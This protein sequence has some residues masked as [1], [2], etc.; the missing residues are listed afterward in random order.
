MRIA[1]RTNAAESDLEEIA[2]YIGVAEH[3]PATADRIIDEL[4]D[5][6][7]EIARL[8]E[9]TKLGATSPE[10][11]NEVRLF[12]FKRWVILFRYEAHGIDVLRIADGKQ[13]YFSWRLS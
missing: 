2:F 13:D 4:I 10:I 9:S 6:C 12:P 5:K 11:G 3:S 1:R 7:D 8:S